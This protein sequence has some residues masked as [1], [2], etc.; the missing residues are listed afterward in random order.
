[1][2][3][4]R[5]ILILLWILV[6]YHEPIDEVVGILLVVIVVQVFA[7]VYEYWVVGPLGL[8]FEI[9]PL[10]LQ[11]QNPKTLNPKTVSPQQ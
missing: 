6:V 7:A 2:K 10:K 4:R 11:A 1:M 8:G 5:Q 9:I 3:S